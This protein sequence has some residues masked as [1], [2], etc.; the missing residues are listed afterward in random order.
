M[1]NQYNEILQHTTT[2]V[3]LKIVI[4]NQITQ[5]RKRIYSVTQFM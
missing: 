3:N 2:W 4:L 1:T 5:T